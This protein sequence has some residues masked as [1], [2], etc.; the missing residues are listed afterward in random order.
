MKGQRNKLSA[1]KCHFSSGKNTAR[2]STAVLEILSSSPDQ[3]ATGA[4]S[5]KTLKKISVTIV[6]REN[7]GLIN[8]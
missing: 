7:K 6:P 2:G 4:L 1:I 8:C 5:A 3:S